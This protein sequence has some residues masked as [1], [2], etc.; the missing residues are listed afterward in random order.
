MHPYPWAKL[1]SL[2]L[3]SNFHDQKFCC[4]HVQIGMFNMT[5]ASEAR[6]SGYTNVW[7]QLA[8]SGLI[9]L[10]TKVGGSSTKDNDGLMS[11][12]LGNQFWF[13]I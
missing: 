13:Q 3:R 6:K 2:S 10:I 11:A 5:L 7:S 4:T 8:V 1:P 9:S 12:S